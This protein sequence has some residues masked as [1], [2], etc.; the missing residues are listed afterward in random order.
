[1]DI[2]LIFVFVIAAFLGVELISK[3]PSQLHTPLMSGTNAISGITV[4]GAITVTAVSIGGKI[5][6]IPAKTIIKNC[7]QLDPWRQSYY[8]KYNGQWGIV[9]DREGLFERE[10]IA[11]YTSDEE[12]KIYDKYEYEC[13]TVE[14]DYEYK[15][16]KEYNA[17]YPEHELNITN[18]N[19]Y[20]K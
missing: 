6:T 13:T 5:G 17:I 8:V 4:V 15:G 19:N 7:I 3:V 10:E 14:C 16:E 12:L 9:S 1:M 2:M 18:I 11:I 20:I